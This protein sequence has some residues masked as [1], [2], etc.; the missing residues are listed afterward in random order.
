METLLGQVDLPPDEAPNDEELDAGLQQ[1]E[2]RG[3]F[4]VA[5]VASLKAEI[6]IRGND[7]LDRQIVR[8]KAARRM[9]A[10]GMRGHHIVQWLEKVVTAVMTPTDAELEGMAAVRS[11]EVGRRI[12]EQQTLARG[13]TLPGVVLGR[14]S[15]G[16]WLS[17]GSHRQ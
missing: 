11:V 4:I 8:E 15:L 12:R 1:P 17:S 3:R 10:R 2:I 13:P 5:L 9:R 7:P 16:Q 14:W 6:T